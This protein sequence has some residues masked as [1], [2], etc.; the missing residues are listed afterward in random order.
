MQEAYRTAAFLSDRLIARDRPEDLDHLQRTQVVVVE[1]QY[2]RGEGVLAVC[3]IPST[4]VSAQATAALGLDPDQ[5]LFVNCPGKLPRE[6]LLRLRAFVEAGGLLVTTDW[7]LRHVIEPAFPGTVRRGGRDSKDDVVRVVFEPV[8]DTFLEGLLDPQ[9]DPLWWLEGSSYPIEVLD[10]AVRVL[11][12]SAE[13]QARY[14]HAPV[15]VAFE[16]GLGKVYHMTSHFYL[17]RSETRTQ[18]HQ[19]GAAEYLTQKGLDPC[20]SRRFCEGSAVQLAEAQSAYTSARSLKN[21]IIEQG[22]RKQAR[23]SR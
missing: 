22:R 18:R 13:M 9:D 1:G 3:G 4:R 15:V 21:L 6:G 23:S 8:Q 7:A 17:Q 11:V 2:D 5:V 19:A 14:G 16:V 20:E 12:S 10:P